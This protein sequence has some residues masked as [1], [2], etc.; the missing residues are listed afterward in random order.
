M[1]TIAVTLTEE[2]LNKVI[3][4]YHTIQVFLSKA[5]SPNELYNSEFLNG[6]RAS[7][8]NIR[9]GDVK[10]VDSFSDFIS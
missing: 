9:R 8:E 6:L 7:K 1:S 3:E 2:Q 5:L 4:A 10:E